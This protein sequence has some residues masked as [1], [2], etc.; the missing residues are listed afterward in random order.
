MTAQFFLAPSAL[1]SASLCVYFHSSSLGG[2]RYPAFW[3]SDEREAQLFLAAG[4]S[5]LA[6]LD[7]LWQSRQ[8]DKLDNILQEIEDETLKNRRQ[9]EAKDDSPHQPTPSKPRV[10]SAR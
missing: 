5:R 9:E 8:F 7:S 3:T 6:E 1:R 10:L 4:E 2:M